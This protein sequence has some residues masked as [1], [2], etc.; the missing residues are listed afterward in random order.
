METSDSIYEKVRLTSV[1]T[2]GVMALSVFYSP[3]WP[4]IRPRPSVLPTP[5]HQR[6]QRLDQTESQWLNRPLTI[7]LKDMSVNKIGSLILQYAS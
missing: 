3:F 4:E 6:H 2:T 7:R 5:P 1:A